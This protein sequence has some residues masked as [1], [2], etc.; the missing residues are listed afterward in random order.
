MNPKGSNFR[1]V[2]WIHYDGS[3]LSNSGYTSE[4]H[5]ERD[6]SG[7]GEELQQN[8]R[9]TVLRTTGQKMSISALRRKHVD[10]EPK[11]HLTTGACED[12]DPNYGHALSN[13]S[14]DGRAFQVNIA[15]SRRR[16]SEKIYPTHL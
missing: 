6:R 1:A 16:W 10:C 11:S 8:C 2:K 13:C 5:E 3:G 4:D 7:H 12:E 9:K 14:E 15:D